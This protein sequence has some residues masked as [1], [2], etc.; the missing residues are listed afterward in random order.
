MALIKCP[1]C[2]KEISNSANK[3]PHCGYAI[4][5]I[6]KTLSANKK[7]IMVAVIAVVVVLFVVLSFKIFSRP[8]I[9]M[10]D[11]NTEN[12]E[13]A[14]LMFLG[15]STGKDGDEWEYKD[16]GIKFYNIPVISV[17]YDLSEGK[18]HLFFDGEYEDRLRNTI[19]KYC[20]YS[21]LVYLAYTYTYKELKVSVY[22][23]ADYISVFIE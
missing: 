16:C 13:F 5:S 21:K 4:K 20:D 19:Q 22:Y 10:D 3:C 7:N 8:N 11:F 6:G 1:E 2:G 23:D 12:G 17:S 14:T 9:K 15:A 18:Y